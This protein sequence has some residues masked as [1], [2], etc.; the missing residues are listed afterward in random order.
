MCSPVSNQRRVCVGAGGMGLSYRA[1]G[2]QRAYLIPCEKRSHSGRQPAAGLAKR[3][4]SRPTGYA[5]H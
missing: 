5:C 2:A 1:G 4:A 3:T